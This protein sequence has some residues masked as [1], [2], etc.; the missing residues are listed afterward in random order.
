MSNSYVVVD[1]GGGTMTFGELRKFVQLTQ[2]R[3]ADDVV[4][5]E[6][7]LQ[8]EPVALKAFV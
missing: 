4:G 1:F 5:I 3:D 8:E 2:E 7:D 6:F